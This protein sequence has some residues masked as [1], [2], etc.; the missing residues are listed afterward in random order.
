M[1]M[2]SYRGLL[3]FHY[4]VGVFCLLFFWLFFF[5]FPFAIYDDPAS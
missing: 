4:F 1:G 2:R 5:F 3:T